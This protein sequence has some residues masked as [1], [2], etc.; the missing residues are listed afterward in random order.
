M[1]FLLKRGGKRKKI[2][3]FHC[4]TKFLIIENRCSVITHRQRPIATDLLL[5]TLVDRQYNKYNVLLLRFVINLLL[6]LWAAFHVCV[7]KFAFHGWEKLLKTVLLWCT[8]A[9]PPLTWW[10]RMSP[11][12]WSPSTTAKTATKRRRSQKSNPAPTATRTPIATTPCQTPRPAGTDAELL[13]RRRSHQGLDFSAV[14]RLY[15]A[16][17]PPLRPPEVQ[18]PPAFHFRQ[19]CNECP[20]IWSPH[21]YSWPQTLRSLWT[22]PVM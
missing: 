5:Y 7:W 11:A 16:L 22:S 2:M 3:S 19:D 10:R 21:S 17:P 1:I 9:A 18:T 20:H 13:G 15:G 14:F 8:A 6:S 4:I 12:S